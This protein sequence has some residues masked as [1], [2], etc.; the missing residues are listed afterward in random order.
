MRLFLSIGLLAEVT[1]PLE[2]NTAEYVF[3]GGLGD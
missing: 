1:Y 3:I 2:L